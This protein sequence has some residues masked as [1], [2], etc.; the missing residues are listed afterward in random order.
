MTGGW[1]PLPKMKS[2][3]IRVLLFSEAENGLLPII[4]SLGIKGYHID[5]M[6]SHTP[7]SL[8]LTKYLSEV[9]LFDSQASEEVILSQIRQVIRELR[10]DVVM[11]VDLMAIRFLADHEEVLQKEVTLCPVPSPGQIQLAHDKWA[12]ANF[13]QIHQIPHPQTCLVTPQW[14][15]ESNA[16]HFPLI[17]KPSKAQFGEGIFA[18]YDKDELHEHGKSI[19]DSHRYYIA[20]PFIPGYDVDCSIYAVGGEIKAYTIQRGVEKV[21]DFTPPS[22]LV[23][24]EIPEVLEIVKR[25]ARILRWTGVAHIDLRFDQATGTFLL[26]ENNPRYWSSLLAST[27]AGVNF[28]DYIIQDTLGRMPKA[29]QSKPTR[30]FMRQ[31]SLK[32]FLKA[33]YKVRETLWYYAMGD[34]LPELSEHVPFVHSLPF[35]RKKGKYCPVPVQKK[36]MAMPV[37]MGTAA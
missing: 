31:F 36:G 30:F 34:L 19:V 7:P 17:L 32:R 1:G 10:P 20:Q 8:L 35:L 6:V 15:E 27:A 24:E 11:G 12:M 21:S 13:C 18:C 14:L 29:P 25:M 28:P 23:F 33:R 37:W 22:E 4:R 26:L 16:P 9:R 5:L 2:R 3:K